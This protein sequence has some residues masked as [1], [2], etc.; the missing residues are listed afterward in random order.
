[1][2]SISKI[3]IIMRYRAKKAPH[4]TQNIKHKAQKYNFLKTK[5]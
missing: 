3:I 4:K 1:M 5:L 2:R